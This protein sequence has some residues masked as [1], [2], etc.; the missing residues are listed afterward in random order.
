MLLMAVHA[1]VRDQP[2]EVKRAAVFL[3]VPD[4]IQKLLLA[5]EVSVCNRLCDA[6]KLLIDD[7]PRADIE[8]SDFRI[9][10]LSVGKTH[11]HTARAELRARIFLRQPFDIRYSLCID[12]VPLRLCG[13][14]EAVHNNQCCKCH[15][16]S[17]LPFP[18]LSAVCGAAATHGATAPYINNL[19]LWKNLPL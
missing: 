19:L 3:Y 7:A 4:C 5:E 14:A 13:E 1:A 10:H 15:F 2:D 16:L 8:M 11:G 18:P 12:G 6:G 17:T 9:A